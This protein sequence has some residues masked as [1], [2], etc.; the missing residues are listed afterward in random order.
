LSDASGSRNVFV[1]G[2]SGYLGRALI[3]SLLGRSHDVC[4]LV[5]PGSEHK[6][7]SGCRSSIGDALVARSF[8]AAVPPADTLVQLVGVP[9]PAPWKKDLF[10]A[11][12]GRSAA[13]ALEAARS[14]EV[15]HFVYVSV[16]QPA[17]VMKS[18][19]AVRAEVEARIRSSRLPA[20]ILRPWYVL[21]PGHRWPLALVPLYGILAR[22]PPTREGAR[23]LGLLSLAEM[24]AALLW[25]IE[26]PPG[27]GETRILD[28]PAIRGLARVRDPRA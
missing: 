10:R 13:A 12:D 17:P 25:A 14:A 18:Y 4:A 20:T 26:H 28:V 27:A 1:T 11:I 24:T 3:R 2:G 6:L 9:R 16:A 5:R 19:V 7:P 23:R 21:G 22:L 15:R 8:A